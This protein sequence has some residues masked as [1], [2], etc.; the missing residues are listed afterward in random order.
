MFLYKVMEFNIH[1]LL[2]CYFHFKAD[3][4]RG[5]LGQLPSQKSLKVIQTVTSHLSVVRKQ[6]NYDLLCVTHIFHIFILLVFFEKRS[7][8]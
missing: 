6:L 4:E 2:S 8:T 7:F 3:F 1:G 5:R